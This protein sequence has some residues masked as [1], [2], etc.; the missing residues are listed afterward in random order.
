[1]STTNQPELYHGILDISENMRLEFTVTAESVSYDEA[2]AQISELCLEHHADILKSC[3]RQ[4]Q[5]ILKPHTL[6]MVQNCLK[7]GHLHVRKTSG[8]RQFV[9]LVIIQNDVD[10]AFPRIFRYFKDAKRYL[11]AEFKD[12][13][14]FYFSIFDNCTDD[15][16]FLYKNR[17]LNII[18][19]LRK[20]VIIEN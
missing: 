3:S 6:D 17:E 16:A 1:M 12:D 11:I 10:Y 15:E 9:Y 20:L 18:L 14:D 19:Q 5:Q 8:P 13:I 4:L 7:Q 2:F